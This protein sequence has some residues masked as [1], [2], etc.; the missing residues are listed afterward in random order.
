MAQQQAAEIYFH[1]SANGCQIDNARWEQRKTQAAELVERRFLTLL[2]ASEHFG[3][4]ANEIVVSR[5]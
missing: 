4:P 5:R 3:L 2:E 1:V